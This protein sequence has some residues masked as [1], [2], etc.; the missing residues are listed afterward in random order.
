M[1]LAYFIQ[2]HRLSENIFGRENIPVPCPMDSSH[3]FPRIGPFCLIELLRLLNMQIH[4][5]DF[6]FPNRLRAIPLISIQ[7][8]LPQ[9]INGLFQSLG[10]GINRFQV[11]CRI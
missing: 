1:T 9:R 8:A 4:S 6:L 11:D 5:N 10:F 7:S 2:I 3:I